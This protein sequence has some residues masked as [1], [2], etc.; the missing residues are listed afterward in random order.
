MQNFRE[1]LVIFNGMIVVHGKFK[2]AA[3][4]ILIFLLS[5][6]N[7]GSF[8]KHHNLSQHVKFQ[9]NRSIQGRDKA[10]YVIPKWPPPPSWILCFYF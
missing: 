6:T 3:A 10:V 4:A 7:N 1:I 8:V 5:Y 9:Q 2:M